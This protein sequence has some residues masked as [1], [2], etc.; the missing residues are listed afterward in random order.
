MLESE[1]LADLMNVKSEDRILWITN[2]LTRIKE[3]EIH[4][5]NMFKEELKAL[6]PEIVKCQLITISIDKHLSENDAVIKQYDII[7]RIKDANYKDLQSVRYT[8]EYF[9]KTGFNPHIH[10]VC[11]KIK[12]NG[13]IAQLIRRKLKKVPEVYNIDVLALDFES[14]DN[15]I[16]GLKKD[17]KMDDVDKDIEFRKDRNIDDIMSF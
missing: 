3:N 16:R 17:D 10:I 8:F 11:D 5:E 12:S 14:A 9:S 6:K 7:Q 4:R 2:W 13:Q 15:Y 1:Y